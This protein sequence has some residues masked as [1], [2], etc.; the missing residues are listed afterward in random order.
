MSLDLLDRFLRVVFI[1][2][3]L[4]VAF[5]LLA[6]GNPLGDQAEV[7]D[8]SDSFGRIGRTRAAQEQR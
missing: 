8:A 4:D 2:A 1:R 7:T 6:V 3:V 5:V